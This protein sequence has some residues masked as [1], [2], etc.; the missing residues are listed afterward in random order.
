M[1]RIA[2][3]G[4]KPEGGGESHNGSRCTG[5]ANICTAASMANKQPPPPEE[6]GQLSPHKW[7]RYRHIN[8]WLTPPTYLY[9]PLPSLFF[10]PQ[11]PSVQ[12]NCQDASWQHVTLQRSSWNL[13][14]E[15][16]AS[17][18]ALV[19]MLP[20]HPTPRSVPDT[21]PATLKAQSHFYSDECISSTFVESVDC[22]NIQW[23]T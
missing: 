15:C 5:T 17:M 13:F 11:I 2:M 6:K 18:C 7:L 22:L 10:S 16:S 4:G 3:Q 20:P 12:D 1:K 19:C 9:P 21:W 14:C 8:P 23:T